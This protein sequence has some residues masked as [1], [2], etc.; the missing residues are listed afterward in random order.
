MRRGQVIFAEIAPR[1]RIVEAAEGAEAQVDGKTICKIARPTPAF[2]KKQM[3]LVRNYADLRADRIPEISIQTGDILSFFGA[4]AQLNGSRRRATLEVLGLV[5]DLCVQLEMLV[6]HLCWRPRPIDFA[7]YVQPVI[8][9]PDHST[10]PSGHATE[11][12]ALAATLFRLQTGKPAA[13]GIAAKDMWFRVAHR[14]AVNRTIAGVHFPVDSAAGAVLGAMIADAAFAVANGGTASVMHVEKN[15]VGLLDK[16]TCDCTQSSLKEA[17]EAGLPAPETAT[18]SLS[19]SKLFGA[20]WGRAA[21]E[22]E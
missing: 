22:W 7:P 20:L 21:K 4:N 16:D 6:K 9:T 8:Q 11:A 19:K 18:D 13:E 10:Y 1:F 2:L 12:Y 17:F 3:V 5:Q 14:I 15:G